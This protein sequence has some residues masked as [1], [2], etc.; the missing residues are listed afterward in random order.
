MGRAKNGASRAPGQHTGATMTREERLLAISD[1]VITAG[2]VKIED[3]PESFGVSL[4]TIHRDLDTLAAQGLLRK[5][6][7]LVT[8]LGSSL[9]E[10]STEYRT[11]INTEAKKAVAKAAFEFIEPGQAIILDDSTTG[12]QLAE[13]LPERLPLTVMTNFQAL[14]D[15]LVGHPELNLISLGGQYYAW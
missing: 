2:S 7:G 6:R 15:S 10:A 8:A 9:A 5:T 13:L 3:L 11:R 4:M 1:A 14:L 12:L